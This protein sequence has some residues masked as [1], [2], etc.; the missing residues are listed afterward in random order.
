M[1]VTKRVRVQRIFCVQRINRYCDQCH[2]Q[3]IRTL[4]EELPVCNDSFH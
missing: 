2:K 3:L 1:C 4:F